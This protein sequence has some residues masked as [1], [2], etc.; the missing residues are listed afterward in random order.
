M[1]L[2]AILILVTMAAT[3]IVAGGV[4]LAVNKSGDNGDNRIIGTN[5]KDRLSG[6]QGDDLIRGRGAED[7]IYGDS[8]EDELF[9]G[10]GP[11]NIFGGRGPDEVFGGPGDDFINV[12][13]EKDNDEVECG[14][15][16]SDEVYAD[17][18]DTVSP[19]PPAGTCEK[20]LRFTI[21]RA[22]AGSMGPM[23]L[24]KLASGSKN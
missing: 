2:K 11:D 24:S 7:Q 18:D 6:G 19:N 13:D 21:T 10:R 1:K 16:D 12:L 4:A 17:F 22:G 3:L 23:E 15:G 5:G 8:G 14:P 9:G 20:I